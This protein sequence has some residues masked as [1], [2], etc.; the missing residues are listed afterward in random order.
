MGQIDGHQQTDAQVFLWQDYAW[1]TIGKHLI[2]RDLEKVMQLLEYH[3]FVG[4]GLRK[5]RRM[6]K[7]NKEMSL[8]PH[9]IYPSYMHNFK[10]IR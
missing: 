7:K 1:L 5:K 2:L 3:D 6:K 4:T 9:S 8:G 10:V